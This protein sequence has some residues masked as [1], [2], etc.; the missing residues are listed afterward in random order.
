MFSRAFHW[1][2]VFLRLSLIGYL[3]SRACHWLLTCFP[4]LV[5]GWLH[6]FPRLSV[7]GYMFSRACHWLV[8][9][10]P[11]L[12]ICWLHVFSRA[13]HWLHVFPR[14]SFAGYMFF[15][16][17]AI[18][19]MF[20]RAWSPLVTRASNSRV[21]QIQGFYA[22]RNDCK[23]GL[24]SIFWQSLT[25]PLCPNSLTFIMPFLFSFQLFPDI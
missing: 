22:R 11:A 23:F 17:L 25:K 20:S 18:G 1:F 10:F 6:V 8:T 12:V 14:L 24:V 5:I 4:A 3:F 2:H 9:C 7:I 19:Y 13:C 15:P 16:A 21:L